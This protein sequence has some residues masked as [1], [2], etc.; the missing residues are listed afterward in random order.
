[1]I[2][3]IELTNMCEAMGCLPQT[4]GLYDQ[5]ARIVLGMQAV[6]RAQNEAANKKA[7]TKVAN[8]GK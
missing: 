3:I 7:N 8:K 2:E 5:D 4:G 6:L 1:M